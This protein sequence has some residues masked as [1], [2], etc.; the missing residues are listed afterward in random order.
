M[1]TPIVPPWPPERLKHFHR[2]LEH[3]LCVVKLSRLVVLQILI[4]SNFDDAMRGVAAITQATGSQLE[5]L[6]STAKKLGATTSY[7]ASEVASLM[8]EL[9]RAGFKPEQIERMTAAVMNMARAT[10]TDA[11]QASGIMAATIRQFGM[12]AGD[13]TR[14]ADGLTA[15]ANK[16][17]NTVESLGEA[18]SY[19][20]PV[21]ADANMSLDGL[22]RRRRANLLRQQAGMGNL[23]RLLTA[24]QSAGGAKNAAALLSLPFVFKPFMQDGHLDHLAFVLPFQKLS[25]RRQPRT[26]VAE[27]VGFAT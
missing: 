25:R 19:A 1:F 12:E 2:G 11:T 16:S 24:N 26:P 14:V 18:L 27:C 23:P 20:G 15:A 7:S 22:H 6:R 13:A 21:A 8:T 3:R 5:S 9:G 10:G 4:F 17:F